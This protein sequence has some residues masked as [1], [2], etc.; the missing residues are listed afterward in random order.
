MSTKGM[1]MLLAVVMMLGL[2][3]CSSKINDVLSE[4]M[5]HVI[6]EA[7][8]EV[9]NGDTIFLEAVEAYKDGDYAHAIEKCEEAKEKGLRKYSEAT[10]YSVI[11]SCHLDLDM[12]EEAIEH[13]SKAVELEPDRVEHVVNLAIAY[14]QSGDNGKAKELYI[15]GLEIDPNY[16]ELNSSLGSLYILENDPE[17]AIHCFDRAIEL[18]PSLAVAY[19]NGALA[20]ALIGDFETAD[21]YLEKAI[22]R[23]YTNADIIKERIDALR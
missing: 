2:C 16:A 20:Y 1:S 13:Y 19:G 8:K 11:G 18:D 12:Y 9:N 6:N 10:L 7:T 17:M 3:G 22:V 21:E 14:R 5:N 4:N 15:Q 23:G